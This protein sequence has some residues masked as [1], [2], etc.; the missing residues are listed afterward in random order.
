M[1][2]WTGTPA[3]V[4]SHGADRGAAAAGALV[5]YPAGIDNSWNVGI[6]CGTAMAAGVDDV[7]FL[8]AVIAD[9]EARE[10]VD[11]SRLAVGGQSNGGV[12][13]Y[14]FACQQPDLV[15]VVFAV[16]TENVTGCRPS[17]PVSLLH[18]HGLAD[19]TIPFNGTLLSSVTGTP[20]PSIGSTLLDWGAA[21]GCGGTY[22]TLPFNGRSDVNSYTFTDCPSTTS[23]Q[24][25]RSKNMGHEWP[26]TATRI[27]QT[28]VDPSSMLWSYLAQAWSSRPS[29]APSSV[30]TSETAAPTGATGRTSVVSITF[31]GRDRSY[32]V[33][34]PSGLPAGPRPLVVLLPADGGTAAN[35]EKS[36]VEVG[37]ASAHAIVAYPDPQGRAWTADDEGFISAVIDDVAARLLVDPAHVIVG[38]YS[39]GGTMA[40]KYACDRSYRVSGLFV[41]AGVGPSAPC[42]L[43]RPISL[44][45]IHGL[46]DPVSPYSSATAGALSWATADGCGSAY[47][48]TNY[49]GRSDVLD[50][51]IITCPAGASVE[52][53]RSK[54][55]T[56]AWPTTASAISSTGVDPDSMLWTWASE[57]WD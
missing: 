26:D 6:C 30:V 41:V 18:I 14:E 42:T 33:F 54:S 4:E 49:A 35:L 5:A 37:A 36:G 1:H 44:L 28:G 53:V 27:Q 12:L 19:T 10:L 39:S 13:A 48:T 31:G 50:F 2:G 43:Q 55:M 52:L 51:R 15:N 40:Y 45:H 57:L 8:D 3:F 22:T 24:L 34:V 20:L 29:L 7:G 46:A 25:V 17:T 56:N 11:P 16:A 38:G 21:D 23:V 32:R 47:S 9:V